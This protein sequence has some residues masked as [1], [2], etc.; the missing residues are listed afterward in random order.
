MPDARI[1]RL[2]ELAP[3]F[4][5]H[6]THGVIKLSDYFMR[7]KWVMLFSHPADFTPS[8]PPSLSSSPAAR[9]TGT[10]STSN[11][12]GVSIDSLSAHIAWVLDLERLSGLKIDFPIVS[13]LDQRVSQA[14][15]LVHEAVSET[16]HR[17]LR[18][19]HRPQRPGSRPALLPQP[20]R[21]QRDEIVR[22]LEA[23]Q[24]GD[25]ANVSCPANWKPGDPVVVTAPATLAEAQKRTSGASG[26]DVQ[27]WY[28]ATKPLPVK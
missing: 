22:I 24:L 25:T 27:T 28:L 2:L 6:S 17:S 11:P 14:Y 4:E 16:A 13:D 8:A 19:P 23:L 5:A 7:G 21:P 3:N 15:G 1:P 20:G 12:I 9:P 10:A 18:L 26:M